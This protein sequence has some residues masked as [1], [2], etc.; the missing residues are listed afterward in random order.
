MRLV[1]AA[2][3]SGCDQLIDDGGDATLHKEA[4][5]LSF[6]PVICMS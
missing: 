5:V 3:T 2:V 1:L 6:L 4:S